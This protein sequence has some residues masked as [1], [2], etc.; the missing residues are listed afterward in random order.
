MHNAA[1]IR[2]LCFSRLAHF[3]PNAPIAFSA[4]SAHSPHFKAGGHTVSNARVIT[5]PRNWRNRRF[6][7]SVRKGEVHAEKP[8]RTEYSFQ[9]HPLNLEK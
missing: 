6:V 2:C 1:S 3:A 9:G 5:L 4:H 7:Y 8:K